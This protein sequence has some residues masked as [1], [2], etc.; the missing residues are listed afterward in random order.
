MTGTELLMA[1]AE[2]FRDFGEAEDI[3]IVFT[4]ESGDARY[5][6]NCNYTRSLGLATWAKADITADL[7]GSP[8]GDPDEDEKPPR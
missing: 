8:T 1:V 7:V 5:K 4:T 3:L 6:S 2:R